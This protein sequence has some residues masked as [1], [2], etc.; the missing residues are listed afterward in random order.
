VAGGGGGSECPD[1]LAA[2]TPEADKELTNRLNT[3][4]SYPSKVWGERLRNSFYNVF[5]VFGNFSIPL[6]D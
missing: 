6:I 4:S 1:I 5:S 3:L 2:A